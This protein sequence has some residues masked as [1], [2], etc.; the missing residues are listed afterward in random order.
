MVEDAQDAINDAR[1]VEADTREAEK[2][3]EKGRVKIA[4]GG[5]SGAEALIKEAILKAAAA[6]TEE[7][8]SPQG[9][10]LESLAGIIW[11]VELIAGVISIGAAGLGVVGWMTRT[12]RTRRKSRILFK[13][14]LEEVDDVYSHFKMNA[15]R[16]EAEL[17]RIKGDVFA[18]F[19]DGLIEEEGFHTLDTRI[20]EYIKDVRREIEKSEG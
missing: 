7:P 17:L 16:C 2:L 14:M 19:K 4:E 13:K 20:D 18:G 15:R 12:R 10:G 1:L 6:Q 11:S 5:L 9:V 3:L 8:A